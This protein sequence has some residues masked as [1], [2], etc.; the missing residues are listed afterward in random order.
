MANIKGIAVNGLVIKADS[1]GGVASGEE[2]IDL[3]KPHKIGFYENK[4]IYEIWVILQNQTNK[5]AYNYHTIDCSNLPN[6]SRVYLLSNELSDYKIGEDIMGTDPMSYTFEKR[7]DIITS[8]IHNNEREIKG[9]YCLKVDTINKQM[10]I[11]YTY[12]GA[13]D[14]EGIVVG[15]TPYA[16]AHIIFA[17]E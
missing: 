4:N 17:I 15:Q 13:G 2:N 10:N 11:N 8:V 3:A 7:P 16:I 6:F 12:T 9:A 1:D 14:S 5:G